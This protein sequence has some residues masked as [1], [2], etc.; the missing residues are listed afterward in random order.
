M[1]RLARLAIAHPRR[2]LAGWLLV[3]ALLGPLGMKLE[4]R[5]HRTDLSVAGTES[6]LAA[7]LARK[8][9]GE[10]STLAVALHGPRGQLDRRGRALQR[11]LER[12]RGLTVLAPWGPGGVRALRPERGAVLLLVRAGGEFDHVARDVVPRIRSDVE[13]LVERPLRSNVTG[14]ADIVSGIHGSTVDAVKRAE[15]LAGPLLAL[16]LLLVFRGVVAAALPLVVGFTTIVAGRGVLELVN[17]SLDLDAVALNL[18][19][20]MGL[21]LGVDYA[22]L[23]VSRFRE[24][25]GGGAEPATAA[26]TAVDK[27]GHTILFAGVAFG[28]AMVG[29]LAVAPGELLRSAS[30]GVI[31][32]VVLSVAAA[33]TALP[34][35]LVML[36]H[37]VDRWSFRGRGDTGA[38]WAGLALRALRRPVVAGGAVLLVVGVLALQATRLETGPFDPRVLPEGSEERT[39]YAAVRDELGAGWAAPY[40]VTVAARDE[41]IT[42]PKLLTALARF[43]RKVARRDDVR[44][45]LGPARVARRARAL[46]PAGVPP[47]GYSTLAVLD[48]APPQVRR[49]AGFAV[50]LGRGGSAAQFAV[51]GEGRVSRAG[52]PLRA[53]LERRAQLLA[54]GTGAVA[55]VGG[56]AATLQDF[57]SES[58]GRLW[59][60]ALA[61]C[62]VSYLVLVPV[63]RSPV[64]PAL[65]VVLNLLTVAAAFGVLVLL[66]QGD[67]PFGGPGF[68]DA[69]MVSGVLSVVFGLSID[70]EVFL[71]ARMREGHAKT[72]T[73]DGAI[74]YGLRHTA[75]IIT[76]AALIMTAVF[77]AFALSDVASMRQ[78][79]TGLTV[80]VLLD[81]TLVRLVLLPAAIKLLGPAA[82]WTPRWLDRLFGGGGP[83]PEPDPEPEPAPRRPTPPRERP[84]PP[85][86]TEPDRAAAPLS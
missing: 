14:Y 71:L 1:R 31:V 6:A 27:A 81:A 85:S 75:G 84:A 51:I 58:F 44:A 23:M 47:S 73:T 22:L 69:I 59:L 49:S 11:T 74:E 25:L 70:Y 12:R 50:N 19:S 21:A 37:N 13:R 60:L 66:F 8:H 29:A 42:H 79:G 45:V 7:D 43:Q 77:V 56:P 65:A 17:R 68:I 80:A 78:L 33:L 4:D 34:A 63:L 83:E 36:G 57:D 55:R 39:D 28:A 54:G 46:T 76:G 62:V 67:A 72:G 2:V 5:L 35:V 15:F 38:R 16:I 20:M 41:R 18:T 32:A 82:W 30:F 48:S 24:E 10:S 9:F 52:H 64:L 61:L 3:V 53:F 86:P 40:Q 26:R